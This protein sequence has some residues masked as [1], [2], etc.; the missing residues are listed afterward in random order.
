MFT[1]MFDYMYMYPHSQINSLS[2]IETQFQKIGKRWSDQKI[3][4]KYKSIIE[5]NSLL[6][7]EGHV[8]SYNI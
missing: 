3:F 2:I 6:H 7:K 4:N 1:Q 8:D 5:H